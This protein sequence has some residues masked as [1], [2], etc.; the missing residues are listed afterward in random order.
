MG[1]GDILVALTSI[2]TRYSSCPKV[3]LS[4]KSFSTHP[5]LRTVFM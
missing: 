3:M 1:D 5:S 4:A 2:R